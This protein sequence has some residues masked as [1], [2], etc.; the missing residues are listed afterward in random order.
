VAAI[1]VCFAND[2]DILPGYTSWTA[3]VAER[4]TTHQA[5]DSAA[6]ACSPP[7]T[8]GPN[9]SPTCRQLAPHLT[10][11]LEPKLP[12]N[13]TTHSQRGAHTADEPRGCRGKRRKHTHTQT[14]TSDHAPPAAQPHMYRESL[15]AVTAALWLRPI[16][17]CR[18]AMDCRLS[19]HVGVPQPPR[20]PRPSRPEP[21]LPHVY[22]HPGQG[23]HT[24]KRG[25]GARS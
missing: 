19:T 1:T 2:I 8:S 6:V 5:S 13:K 10:L 12:C 23:G 18:T 15:P 25:E 20:W 24:G 4:S 21:L 7:H 3:A 11:D 9:T 17:T 16:A 14:P 22:L